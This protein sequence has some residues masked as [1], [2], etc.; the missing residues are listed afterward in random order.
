MTASRPHRRHRAPWATKALLVV[1]LSMTL[2]GCYTYQ[3]IDGTPAP[4]DEISI[5]LTGAGR[6][7]LEQ[8]R[9]LA[10][11]T[12]SGRFVAEEDESVVVEVRLRPTRSVYAGT[13]QTVVDTLALS[14]A[15]I[16]TL[17][18]RRISPART[19]LASILGVAGAA[20]LYQIAVASSEDGPSGGPDGGNI[21]FSI[22][23]PLGRLAAT[24][25]GI[26]P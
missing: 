15:D 17:S 26:L 22:A 11:S 13:D 20:S 16:R 6:D 25:A 24:V 4:R 10:L 23:V 8:D 7:Q 12:V 2:G 21:L 14:R 3:P 18:L 19:V 9:G 1:A 5:E